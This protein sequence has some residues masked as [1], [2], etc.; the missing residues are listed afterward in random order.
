MLPRA[1]ASHSVQKPRNYDEPAA[2]MNARI[3][4][5]LRYMLCV[6][7]LAHYLKK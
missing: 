1:R 3:S 7:R 5:L 6:S 4:A 2:T